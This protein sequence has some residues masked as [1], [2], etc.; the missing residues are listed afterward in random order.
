E[1]QEAIRTKLGEPLGMEPMEAAL[2][3]LQIVSNNMA[4]AIRSKTIQKGRDP[5]QFTLVSFGGAGPMH[6]ADIAR[7]LNISRTLIPANSGVLSAV[8]LSTTDLQYDDI[9]TKF[10]MFGDLDR[11][12]LQADYNNL[13]GDVREHLRNAGINDQNIDLEMTADCR[14]EGQGYELSVSVGE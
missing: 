7:E 6:A 12:T 11:E 4:N 14:Y 8:G 5:K 13:V 2:G 1:P 9:N 10:S 3:I